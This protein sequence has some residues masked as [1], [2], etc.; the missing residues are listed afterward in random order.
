MPVTKRKSDGALKAVSKRVKTSEPTGTLLSED[1]LHEMTK[2]DLIQYT[3]QLQAEFAALPKPKVPSAEEIEKKAEKAQDMLIRGIEKQMKWT[4]SC[5]TG[6][7]KFTYDGTVLNET[8][9]Q[10]MLGLPASHTKK[11]FK[12]SVGYFMDNVGEPTGSVRYNTLRITSADINVRW[13]P[14]D[15]TFKV[16]GAYGL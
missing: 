9:F 16:S 4:P 14:E 11:M 15:G 5:K 8:I 1:E 10:E 7:A 12:I 2:E 13:S 6:K 3:L